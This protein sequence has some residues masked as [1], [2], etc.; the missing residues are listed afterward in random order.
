MTVPQWLDEYGSS[1]QNPINKAIH[2][3]CVPIITV[4]LVALLSLVPLPW[5]SAGINLA[6]LFLIAALVF[7]LRLSVSLGLGMFIVSLLTLAAVHALSLLPF[8]LWITS[9][10]L[11]TTHTG[12]AQRYSHR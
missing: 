1:H 9:V 6:H 4:T 3:V 10:V 5:E 8:E 12:A 11:P 2:W 7:Y